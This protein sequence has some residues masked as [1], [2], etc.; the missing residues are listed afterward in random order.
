M[1]GIPIYLYIWHKKDI[2][3]KEQIKK[4]SEVAADP[5]LSWLSAKYHDS[6]YIF[7]IAEYINNGRADTLKEALN[8]L[9]QE[10]HQAEMKEA[11]IIGAYYGAQSDRY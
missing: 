2:K 9:E 6:F 11:A 4:H 10:I 3:K 8:M 1:L 5:S 7:K